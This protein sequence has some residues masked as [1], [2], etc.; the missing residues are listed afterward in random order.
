MSY[1]GAHDVI[2]CGTSIKSFLKIVVSLTFTF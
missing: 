1:A 2:N